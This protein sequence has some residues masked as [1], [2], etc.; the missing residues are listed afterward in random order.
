MGSH[1]GQCADGEPL[2]LLQVE[3]GRCHQILRQSNPAHQFEIMDA[4]MPTPRHHGTT[5]T[6]GIVDWWIWWIQEG[7][8]L[9]SESMEIDHFGGKQNEH[10]SESGLFSI[11]S[12]VTPAL[13]THYH[14][15]HRRRSERRFHSCFSS[16]LS[17]RKGNRRNESGEGEGGAAP[18]NGRAVRLSGYHSPENTG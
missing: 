4:D 17:S 15:P 12:T 11:R 9:Q 8:E 13:V 3:A 14:Q 10:G 16:R 6:M 2:Q 5:S 18:G 1:T 7:V